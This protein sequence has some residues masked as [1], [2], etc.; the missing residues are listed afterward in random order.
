[1]IE[2]TWTKKRESF[3]RRIVYFARGDCCRRISGEG[4]TEVESL[5]TNHE[6]ADTKIAYLTQHALENTPELNHVCVRSSSGDIDITVILV[7]AFGQIQNQ[8]F[9]DNGT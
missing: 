8:I 7:A 9:I 1:M 2:E 6:E 3:G 5:R 4:V